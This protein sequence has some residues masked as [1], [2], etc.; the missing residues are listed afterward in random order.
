MKRAYI[1]AAG[2]ILVALG[3]GLAWQGFTHKHDEEIVWGLLVPAYVYFA[4]MAVGS[5]IVNSI[6]TVFGYRG[7]NDELEKIAKLGVAFSLSTIIPSWVIILLDINY[8]L[9]AVKI[10]LPPEGGIQFKYASAISWMALL[11]MFIALALLVELVYFIRS[12]VNERLKTAKRLKLAI[13]LAVLI[14]A[15]ILY[16]NLGQVFGNAMAVPG[17]YGPHMALFFIASS[18]AIGAAGQLL[19]ITLSAR[20]LK[21][22]NFFGWYYGRII[23]IVIPVLAFI[24]GWMIINAT[25]NPATWEA[26]KLLLHS[27]LF[28]LEVLLVFIVPFTLATAAYYKRSLPL[29]LIAALSL[30]VGGFVVKYNILTVPQLATQFY[31]FGEVHLA[32]HYIPSAPEVQIVAGAVLAYVGILMLA[33][34]LLPLKPGEKPRRIL[35]FK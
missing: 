7:P 22:A 20:E 4:L 24:K 32:E 34:A 16:S 9:N 31:S 25:Y 14:I 23:M 35:I 21:M 27:P 18:I 5:S 3:A 8:P 12:E 1:I 19:F 17:W 33:V 11:Y 28:Y 2:L 29:A 10:F 26:Y 6:Y 30:V 13:A 15:V